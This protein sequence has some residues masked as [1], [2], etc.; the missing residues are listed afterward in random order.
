MTP[1]KSIEVLLVEDDPAD[2]ELTSEA[3]KDSKM[4]VTL[5]V[6]GDGVNAMKFLNQEAPYAD[7]SR[8]DL[9]I[10]DLNLPRM[11]GREVLQKISI[12]RPK[13]NIA[14]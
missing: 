13:N 9:V 4:L 5:N 10:L 7:A 8:P 2:V 14:Q 1:L 6:V 11:S 12:S 3:L